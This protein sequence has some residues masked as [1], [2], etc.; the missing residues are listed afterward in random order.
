LRYPKE[1]A[2][3]VLSQEE[4]QSNTMGYGYRLCLSVTPLHAH[5]PWTI[6]TP[7]VRDSL[8]IVIGS[9]IAIRRNRVLGSAFPTIAR[10]HCLH[11]FFSLLLFL[12]PHGRSFSFKFQHAMCWICLIPLS[13]S[14]AHS[15]YADATPT[16]PHNHH[17]APLWN[18]RFIAYHSV[19]LG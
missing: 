17:V 5:P 14:L 19:V 8:P 15:G 11:S 9:T 3:I 13:N 12:L 18:S 4:G 6:S 2:S 16:H 1:A 10:Q 7:G